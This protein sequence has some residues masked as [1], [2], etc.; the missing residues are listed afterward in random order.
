MGYAMRKAIQARRAKPVT[1]Q[2]GLIGAIGT[3]KTA[4]DPEGTV[5][6][7]GE[8]WHGMSEDGQAIAVGNQVEVIALKGLQLIVKKIAKS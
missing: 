7:W 4:L 1:G 5:F 3:V 8:R 2:E 6:V